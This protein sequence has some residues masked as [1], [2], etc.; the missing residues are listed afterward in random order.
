MRV[1]R[2]SIGRYTQGLFCRRLCWSLTSCSFISSTT[3][4]LTFYPRHVFRPRPSC[5]PP[6]FSSVVHD[7]QSWCSTLPSSR[8]SCYTTLAE[9]PANFDT[10]V[11]PRSSLSNIIFITIH[12]HLTHILLNPSRCNSASSFVAFEPLLLFTQ[13]FAK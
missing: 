11:D 5:I 8:P 9:I 10:R 3:R 13:G 12:H 4:H 2:R 7:L 6:S 1:C